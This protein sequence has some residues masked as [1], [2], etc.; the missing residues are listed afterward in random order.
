MHLDKQSSASWRQADAPRLGAALQDLRHRT[1]QLFDAYVAAGQ[2]QVPKSDELNPPLW[3]LGHIGWFQEFWIGRNQERDVGIRCNPDHLRTSSL[4]E[5]ADDY[6][7]SSTVLHDGRWD[8]SLPDVIATK[9]YLAATLEQTLTLLVTADNTDDALYFYRL[10]LFHEAMHLEAA[11]YM[12]QAL[13][14]AVD[15]MLFATNL[16][17]D[18]PYYSSA[19]AKI[20][21]KNTVF[22]IGWHDSG[23]AF[24]NELA[25]QPMPLNAFEIDSQAVR[26]RQY[27]Q[28]VQATGRALPRYVR[29]APQGYEHQHFGVWQ[30]LDMQAAAVHLSWHDAQAYCVW[31]G[32]RLPT[33]AE[34][35]CAALTSNMAWGEVW[36]WTSSTFDAYPGFVAHPY[37]DYSAPWFGSRPVLKGACTATQPNMRNAKYRNYFMADRTD[38]FAGFRTCAL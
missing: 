31:A 4:L 25:T 9:A 27:L 3:E 33:E 5:A 38:I 21:I 20:N 15:N 35:E 1:L 28:F 29:K 30:A 24:D 13:G 26:W 37:R 22:T 8:L 19:T 2:L 10:V 14:V 17:A 6:Y 23:F 34:W 32:R 11:V 12:A 36:E 16:I 7:N 18:K